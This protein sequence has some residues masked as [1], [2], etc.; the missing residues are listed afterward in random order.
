MT[1]HYRTSRGRGGQ[2]EQRI[3]DGILEAT[4]HEGPFEF[5]HYLERYDGPLDEGFIPRTAQ[6][7]DWTP[8]IFEA[9]DLEE[10]ERHHAR[11]RLDTGLTGPFRN[12][13]I[14]RRAVSP[15]EVFE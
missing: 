10:A 2:L 1:E 15:W 12:S 11:H 13:R 6:D 9:Q 8:L 3:R 14:V 7:S 4:L 5:G